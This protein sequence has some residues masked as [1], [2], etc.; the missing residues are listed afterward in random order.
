MTFDR[1]KVLALVQAR[2]D[3]FSTEEK[4]VTVKRVDQIVPVC[5]HTQRGTDVAEVL[6]T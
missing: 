4:E 1:S 2:L 6:P 5:A 3:L